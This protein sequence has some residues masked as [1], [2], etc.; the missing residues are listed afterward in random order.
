MLGGLSP[1]P[2]TSG[3]EFKDICKDSEPSQ[4]RDTQHKG[5]E[6]DPEPCIRNQ[7]YGTSMR[8]RNHVGTSL[9]VTDVTWKVKGV[10]R[11]WRRVLE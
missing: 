9:E 5:V 1:S 8:D 10:S 2:P 7:G 11:R 4:D 3:S 6:L